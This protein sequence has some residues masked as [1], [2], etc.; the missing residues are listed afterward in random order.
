VELWSGEFDPQASQPK[1][2]LAHSLT[3]TYFLLL[4]VVVSKN[5]SLA[6]CSVT[7]SLTHSLHSHSLTH[8]INYRCLAVSL[9]FEVLTSLTHSLTH[10]CRHDRGDQFFLTAETAD[11]RGAVLLNGECVSECVCEWRSGLWGGPHSLTHLL[12]SLLVLF[13]VLL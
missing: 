10:S 7:H 8:L 5:I 13:C 9:F 2:S 4:V 11:P 1:L 3:H 12:T 6:F